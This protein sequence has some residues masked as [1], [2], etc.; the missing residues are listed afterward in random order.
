MSVSSLDPS[1]IAPRFG[2]QNL[3]RMEDEGQKVIGPRE[4]YGLLR[5]RFVLIAAIVLCGTM[6]AIAAS[7]LVPKTYVARSTILLEPDD[8]NLLDDATTPPVPQPN[9]ATM[10]T[11][12]DLITSRAFVARVVESL[13]LVQDPRFNPY[14]GPSEEPVSALGDGLLSAIL[15]DRLELA[16]FGPAAP[17]APLPPLAVQQD[18]AISALLSQL[19][20]ARSGDS[21]AMTVGA[22]ADD[23]VLA[24]TIANAVTALFVEWAREQKRHDMREAVDF[25]RQQS[26]ELASNIARTE[27]EIASFSAQNDISSDPRDDLLRAAMAKANDQLSIAHGDLTQAQ[28]RLTQVHAQ[29]AGTAT[30]TD[31]PLL[32]SP[33][34]QSLRNDEAVAMRERAELAGNFGANHP[35]IQ[36]ADAKAASIKALIGEE[37]GRILANL[38]NDVRVAQG[39]VDQ[40]EQ[41][42]VRSN[43]DLRARSVYEIR[44]RELNRDL[45]TE[46][47]LYDRVSD[48]LGKLDPYASVADPG[49]RVISTAEVPVEPFSP[50]PRILIAGG[51]F[52][53]LVVGFVVAMGAESLN[54]RVHTARRA[55]QI[56]RMPILANVPDLP[57]PFFGRR[58][59]AVSHLCGRPT[60]S[61]AR[62]FRPLRA[63][64]RRWNS[65]HRE[66]VVL[67][68]SSLA[69]EGK[70]TTAT[71]LAIAAA[72]EGLHT[73][74]VDLQFGA[75]GVRD[76]ITFD[77]GSAFLS[78]FTGRCD[79]REVQGVPHLSVASLA[80]SSIDLLAGPEGRRP[81][82]LI[83][84]LRQDFDMIVIDAPAILASEEAVA[85]AE[86]VDAVVLVVEAGTVSEDALREA[87]DLLRQADAPLIG[88]VMSRI[89]PSAARESAMGARRTY[90]RDLTSYS[91]RTM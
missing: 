11:K 77:D 41:G 64:C 48:R 54:A 56:L 12:T 9:K 68:T 17:P 16:L 8:P 45:L 39:R 33:V 63:A 70:S 22:T 20:I 66:Q 32:A 69:G 49:A 43:T 24:A 27:S 52:G 19:S 13:G 6:A 75:G 91:D 88:L 84:A 60:S 87:G 4:I 47:K 61:F 78:H 30:P 79:L 2:M 55:M 53:S 89:D 14:L 40:L 10:D 74:L 81:E 57:R 44:L 31:D 50:K 80:P 34:L 21:M 35:L 28:M 46:Q 86:F 36:A 7:V 38:E 29:A 76:A 1:S 82:D 67:V 26:V 3:D 62:G 83:R 18:R 58:P 5:R 59:D 90:R 51:L 65:G 72:S 23:P 25:L 85:L 15:P 71:G 42:L 37:M 73:V